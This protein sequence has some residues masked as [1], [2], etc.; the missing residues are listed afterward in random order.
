MTLDVAWRDLPEERWGVSV[1][2]LDGREVS[3]AETIWLRSRELWRRAIDLGNGGR[4][5]DAPPRVQ[6]RLTE[7]HALGGR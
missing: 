4:L 5:S 3:V 7:E 6:A 2:L 1:R